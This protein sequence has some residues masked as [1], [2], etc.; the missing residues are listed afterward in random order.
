MPVPGG[1]AHES[2]HPD[3]DGEP[4]VHVVRSSLQLAGCT[5]AAAMKP[6]GSIDCAD[7]TQN[8]DTN[9]PSQNEGHDDGVVCDNLEHEDQ[10]K[11]GC[12]ACECD[13]K[14]MEEVCIHTECDVTVME[15]GCI[16]T[17]EQGHVHME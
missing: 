1:T 10:Y 2:P 11:G 16:H 12:E 3:P 13:A 5:V 15:E 4:L 8:T 17:E 7:H 14:V 9:D 6:S